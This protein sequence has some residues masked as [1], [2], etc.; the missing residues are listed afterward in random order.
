MITIPDAFAQR[1]FA[2]F[3][4]AGRAWIDALP[5]L[6]ERFAQRWDIT[7]APP[8]VLSYNYVAPARRPDGTA[9]VLKAGVPCA[10]LRNEIAAL[11]CY[12]GR[13]CVRLLETAMEEGV[14]L[15]ERLEPG[16]TL[17]SLFPHD[18]EQAT[19]IAAG[20]MRRLWCPAPPSHPFPTVADW[21]K[22][23]AR[24]RSRFNGGTGPLPM[25]PVEQAETLFRELTDS[26]V[27]P[28]LL[29]GDLHH[30]NI[31]AG[32]GD[33]LAVDPKGLVGEPAYEAGALLRNPMPHI[34]THPDRSHLLNR[35]I[36]LLA[37]ELDCDAARI[38]GWGM[39][40]AVLSALWSL[41]DSSAEDAECWRAAI[42]FAETLAACPI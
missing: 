42:A 37:E 11:T 16:L 4:A 18:D 30:G 19:R 1:M 36:A 31:L 17:D 14:F 32:R 28:V 6:L 9:V 27:A 22:G 40:Q 20:V 26:S 38:R 34:F 25:R 29:H 23:F 7:L 15:L 21:G 3:G 13:G 41:E 5:A 10:E 33:W 8:F 24:L 39:A 35:R 12:G 2:V